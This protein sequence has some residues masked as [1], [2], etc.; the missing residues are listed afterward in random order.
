[1]RKKLILA[2]GCIVILLT[3]CIIPK[4]ARILKRTTREWRDS[5][6]MFHAWVDSPLSAGFLKLRENGKFEHTSSG[7]I[8]SF[9]AGT[10]SHSQDTISLIYVDSRQNTT[11]TKIVTINRK[12][13]TLVF[14]GDSILLPMRIMTN[15]IK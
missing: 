2:C 5:D 11:D 14:L 8:Q 15:K 1:M 10:W 9:N 6:I 7:L 13:S 12:T 4:D 3:S